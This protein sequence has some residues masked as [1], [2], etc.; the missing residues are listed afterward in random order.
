[1][2]KLHS[3]GS[4]FGMGALGLVLLAA[5]AAGCAAG[6]PVGA[7]CDS[8][9]DCESGAC[10][11]GV[12]VDAET[13]TGSG[14]AGGEGGGAS[15]ATATSSSTST[16][17]G[18]C[19]PNGDGTVE[20]SELPLGPGLSATYRV[21]S[22]VTVDLVGTGSGADRVWDFSG[23]FPGDKSIVIET[24]ALGGTWYGGIFPNASYS[25][26][27][28]DSSD[29]LGVFA[30]GDTALALVG[31][32]SPAEGVSRTEL[33]YETPVPTLQFPLSESSAWQADSN[34][35]GLAQGIGAFYIEQYEFDVDARGTVK[36]PF[37]DFPVLRLRVDLT[38]WIGAVPTTQR[39]FVFVAECFGPVATVVSQPNELTV[40]FTSASE[41]RR[42]TP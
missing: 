33:T 24:T 35:S 26:R 16:G 40:E 1:M 12:C 22:D 17:S 21:A 30:L 19:M 13:T 37:G 39:S 18:V 38:R 7:D 23:A 4:W 29:L 15:Q 2:R 41:L 14:G 36:T 8:G 28:A 3:L 6:S 27:L 42:L 5:G 10:R 32:V 34:V 20:R 25:S 9:A 31:V 11:D